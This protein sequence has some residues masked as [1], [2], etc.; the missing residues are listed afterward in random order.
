MATA[1]NCNKSFRHTFNIYHSG[2]PRAFNAL[3]KSQSSASQDL[4][5][6]Q[7]VQSSLV[8]IY[9]RHVPNNCSHCDAMKS[10][11][12]L[13]LR[14]VTIHFRS[15]VRCSFAPFQISC[16]NQILSGLV[17]VS[18]EELSGIVWK[19]AWIIEWACDFFRQKKNGWKRYRTLPW[20]VQAPVILLQNLG[21]LTFRVRITNDS[22]SCHVVSHV[23]ILISELISLQFALLPLK[24]T[25]V[26]SA[27]NFSR[28]L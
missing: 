2:W 7:W 4:L 1:Q 12:N 3:P 20:T 26:Q 22:I 13:A 11:R 23:Y 9:F 24:K 28:K 27:V 6:F 5:P 14:Y 17:F 25:P 10:N 18:A 19:N 16:Q 15:E 8:L 21:K